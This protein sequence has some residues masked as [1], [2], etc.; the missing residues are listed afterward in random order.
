MS[1]TLRLRGPDFEAGRAEHEEAAISEIAT[2]HIAAVVPG[3]NRFPARRCFPIVP[4]S[5][6]MIGRFPQEVVKF[7]LIFGGRPT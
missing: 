4:I 1:M 3:L 2:T 6:A 5:R 7:L